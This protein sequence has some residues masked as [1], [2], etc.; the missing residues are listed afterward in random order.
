[1]VMD[2]PVMWESKLHEE[3]KSVGSGEEGS[4]CDFQQPS[5]Q[6]EEQGSRSVLLAVLW[7]A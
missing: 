6:S 4:K 7:R 1:M 5:I 3:S 2:Q